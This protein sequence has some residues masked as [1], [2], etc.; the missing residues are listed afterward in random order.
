[1]ENTKI[2]VPPIGLTAKYPEVGTGPCSTDIY[3][4]PEIYRKEIEAVFKR[5]WYMIGRVEQIPHPGDVLT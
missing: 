3:H 2:P 4:D 5:S 1:M